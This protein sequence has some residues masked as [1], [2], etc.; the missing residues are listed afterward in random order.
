M[1]SQYRHGGTLMETVRKL[2]KEGG[3]RRFYRGYSVAM[4]Q[5]PLSR[6]GDTFSNTLFLSVMNQHDSTRKLPIGLKTIGASMC[7]ALYR[8]ILTPIDTTK[9]IL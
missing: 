4:L 2:S 1:N 8:I 9:T 3:I 5:G 6:F 7:A